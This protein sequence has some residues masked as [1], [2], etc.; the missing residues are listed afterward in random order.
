M[1]PTVAAVT[2]AIAERSRESRGRYLANLDHAAHSGPG[3]GKL[4]CANWAH[5][6]A[7]QDAA[8]KLRVMDPKAP[9]IGIVTAYNDM[10]SAHQPFKDFPDLIKAA[11]REAGATAQVAGGEG[12]QG[13]RFEVVG[14]GLAVGRGDARLAGGQRPLRRAAVPVR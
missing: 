5:A 12:G 9:N 2:A 13:G 8:D 1:N 4:S 10:L 11:A 14:S 6:F 3:R 7:A